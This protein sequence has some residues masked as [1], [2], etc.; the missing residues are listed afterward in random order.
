MFEWKKQYL[1]SERSSSVK[2]LFLP[3]EN[4]IHVFEPTLKFL[5]IIDILMTVF[6]TIFRRFQTTFR[7][8]PKILQNLSV[9]HTN[10]GKH[11]QNFP[12]NSEDYRR[13][14]K[15]L[16][17]DLNMFRWITHN[18]RDKLDINK[19]GYLYQ[20][21]YAKYVTLYPHVISREF[22]E[23]CIFQWNTLVGII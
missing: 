17:E 16:E 22:C 8:F 13:L 9:S 12:K 21:G 3:R 23:W 6:L 2:Y 5:F 18:F 15:A 1:T 20:W 4:K 7:L 11:S 10:V 14:L 19:T